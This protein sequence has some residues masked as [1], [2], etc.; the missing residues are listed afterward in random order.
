M[1]KRNKQ[2]S[3]K[4]YRKDEKGCQGYFDIYLMSLK[5]GSK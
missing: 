3:E 5:C 2:K 1:K 4:D